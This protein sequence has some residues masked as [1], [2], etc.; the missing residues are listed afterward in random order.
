MALSCSSVDDGHAVV[1]HAEDDVADEHGAAGRPLLRAALLAVE[2]QAVLDG[3]DVFL[4]F[5]LRHWVLLKSL[6]R[7]H[8]R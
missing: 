7:L 1:L 5:G 3:R 6:V 8:G 4:A 2:A